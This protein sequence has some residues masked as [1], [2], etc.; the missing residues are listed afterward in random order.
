[1]QVATHLRQLL[2]SSSLLVAD[3]ITKNFAGVRALK[4][5]S[6]ELLKGEVHALIGEN[7]AGKSTLTK[8]ITGAISADS[9]TLEVS[10]QVVSHNSPS[11]ARALGIAAI[12]QQPSLFPHLT[13]AENIALALE[14]GASAWKVN[15]KSRH[16]RAQELIECSGVFHR[17][18][19]VSQHAEHGR[20]TNRGDCEGHRH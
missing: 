10:G 5:A 17:S 20:T 9:G 19:A 12:Y 1:M 15:W 3:S 6:L 16:R 8:I 7:G 11:I 2:P 13:V 4:G 14:S 18:P